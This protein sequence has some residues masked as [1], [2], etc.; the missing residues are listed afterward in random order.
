MADRDYTALAHGYTAPPQRRWTSL[1]RMGVWPLT[2][3]ATPR[4]ARESQ[5]CATAAGPGV[6]T[7]LLQFTRGLERA[8]PVHQT[9]QNGLAGGVALQVPIPI[10]R[11][12]QQG[13]GHQFVEGQPTP[14]ASESSPPCTRSS[15]SPQPA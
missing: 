10:D 14:A 11:V 2:I 13:A 9:P 1:V 12:A 4:H 7:Q 6:H 8:A 3:A 5:A 15:V